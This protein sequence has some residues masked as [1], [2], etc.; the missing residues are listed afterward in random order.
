MEPIKRGRDAPIFEKLRLEVPNPRQREF[1][2]STARHTAYGGARGGG[3]SYA[4][5]RKL[6]LLAMRY[7]KLRLLLLRRTLQELRENHLLPLQSELLGYAEYKKEERTF[8]FPNGS[9]LTLGYCDSDSDIL[10]YQGAE[11]DVIGFEEATHFKED[12]M[13]FISTSLRTTKK[14]FEPRIYYTCNPGGV[15]HAYI[16]RLF[17]DRR[18]REGEN[19][20][21][22]AFIPARVWDNRVLMEADPDYVKRLEAL[23]EHK[24]R[25]HLDGDWNVYEGQ[26]FEEFR[27]DPAHFAD[28]L[29]THVIDPFT[30]P[31]GWAIYRSFDFGY[32]KPFSVGWWAKDGDGR[33]Y[34]ILEL[35]GCALRE[36][37]VGVRWTPEEIFREIRRI[38]REH[39]FLRGR[40]IRGVA[41]PAIWDASR[42]ESIAETAERF[43]I[44]FEKGDN[45]RVAGWMQIHNRL[46]FDGRG[47]PMLYVFNTC[48]EFL[49]TV[50]TLQYSRIHPEDVDSDLED[51]IADET[52]YLCMLVPML[53]EGPKRQVT[54]LLLDPLDRPVGGYSVRTEWRENEN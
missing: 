54:P 7:P 37:N 40:S 52:R 22:Y 19:P 10:Q 27:C 13:I 48:R 14:D 34:R 23:P 9:R 6:V 39:P 11:Y 51:H 21:D 41:D 24:R 25:A 30:P 17:I 35:Y 46:A 33:L 16:K 49:R 50:P 31:E 42:G 43:G 29:H 32:A 53:P 45:R 20:D 47:I 44:Y 8:L 36:A 3:K 5:R 4:M 2:L 15:G 1:F 12:W 26:V 28:R 18:F 38:E